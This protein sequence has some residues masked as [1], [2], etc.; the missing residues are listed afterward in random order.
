MSIDGLRVTKV[1][2]ACV[3]AESPQHPH[4][5]P[6]DMIC[7]SS[8]LS[9]IILLSLSCSLGLFYHSFWAIAQSDT[10]GNQHWVC[11]TKA[12]HWSSVISGLLSYRPSHFSMFWNYTSSSALS[13]TLFNKAEFCSD[14]FFFNLC[15]LGAKKNSNHPQIKW[16][17]KNSWSLGLTR[18]RRLSL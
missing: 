1:T 11:F 10:Y 3:L 6:L 12:P 2:H 7:L 4:R 8:P 16:K 14:G 15:S 13:K 9:F 18:A 5:P 17:E